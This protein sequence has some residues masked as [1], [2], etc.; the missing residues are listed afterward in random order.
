NGCEKRVDNDADNCGLGGATGLVG[1]NGLQGAGCKVSCPMVGA[2]N[3]ASRTCATGLCNGDCANGF[4]DC[5]SNK[6]SNGCEKRVDNDPDNCG[7]GGATGVAV[8]NGFPGA[9]C[10]VKCPAVGA[11]NMASRSCATGLCNGN[12]AFNFA[13]CDGN[14][15]S[16]GCERRVD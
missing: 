9:G 3:M 12:C 10:N 16:N 11:V 2:L 15:L 14:K 5:D 1:A 8:A 6:L 13:D 4:A 7:T